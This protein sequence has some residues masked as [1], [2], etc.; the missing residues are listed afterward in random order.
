MVSAL[1]CYVSSMIRRGVALAL[2]ALALFA[3]PVGAVRPFPKEARLAVV[4]GVVL[5]DV[6]VDGQWKRLAPGVL[7]YDTANRLVQPGDIPA[8]AQTAV[9]FEATTG[10]VA[11]VWI[12]TADEAAQFATSR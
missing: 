3:G 7:V 8:N 11:K 12:L 9:L 4:G 6:S 5:P 10:F 1:S 2:V